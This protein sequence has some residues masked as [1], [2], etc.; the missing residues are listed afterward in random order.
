[1][2]LD[3]VL[4]DLLRGARR[5]VRERA[6]QRRG[7]W[8]DDDPSSDDEESSRRDDDARQRDRR[9][10]LR[11]RGRRAVVARYERWM[12][13]LALLVGATWIA[14]LGLLALIVG[15]VADGGFGLAVAIG[16]G[17]LA[18]FGLPPAVWGGTRVRRER[19]QHRDTRAA[20]AHLA[21]LPREVRHDWRR[22]QQARE[23]VGELCEEGWV[24]T[25]AVAELDEHVARLARAL[26]TDRRSRELGGR[27]SPRLAQQ[28]A[29]LADL[30]VALADEGVDQQ[31]EVVATSTAPATLVQARDRMVALRAARREVDDLDQPRGSTSTG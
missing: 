3:D 23:L 26:E 27:S 9:P 16:L 24:S 6:E 8:Q 14:T 29:D 1:M 19:R 12:P 4:E 21:G 20:R 10:D 5:A 2:D 25:E 15:L 7:G 22:M 18:A 13:R 11:D 31:A 28:V 17:A 30:L